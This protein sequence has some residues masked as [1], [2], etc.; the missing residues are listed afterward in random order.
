LK[1]GIARQTEGPSLPIEDL[2][3]EM[4]FQGSSKRR[5]GRGTQEKKKKNGRLLMSADEKARALELSTDYG[6]KG[7]SR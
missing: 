2:R 1:G 4:K 7:E 3:Q 5:L 6:I